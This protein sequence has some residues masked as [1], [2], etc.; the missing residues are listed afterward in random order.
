MP[1]SEI[2]TYVKFDGE[3][4]ADGEASGS[5]LAGFHEV[6]ECDLGA[7]FSATGWW[8]ENGQ[9]TGTV[10][11]PMTVTIAQNKGVPKLYEMCFKRVR[12]EGKEVILQMFRSKK[13]GGRQKYFE[14]KYKDYLIVGCHLTNRPGQESGRTPENLAIVSI[15]AK[16]ITVTHVP[17][18]KTIT[19][20]MATIA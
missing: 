17:S 16:E 12:K 15:V 10:V 7:T 1:V 11:S 9:V 13:E 14:V 19:V 18:S 3:G 20:D 5:D 2:N 6:Y 8:K 4:D